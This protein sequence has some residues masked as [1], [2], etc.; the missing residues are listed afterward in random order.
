MSPAAALSLYTRCVALFVLLGQQ[1]AV[2]QAVRKTKFIN[3]AMLYLLTRNA[4]AS[5]AR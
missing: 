5:D 2:Q 1:A 4:K 3:A